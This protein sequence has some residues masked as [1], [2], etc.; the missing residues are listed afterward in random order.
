MKKS[1]NLFKRNNKAKIF[2]LQSFPNFKV[3]KPQKCFF[4]KATIKLIS[5]NHRNAYFTELP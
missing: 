1:K 4:N 3:Y 2:F 5:V